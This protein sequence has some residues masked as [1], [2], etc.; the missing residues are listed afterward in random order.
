MENK[1]VKTQLGK[2][3]SGGSRMDYQPPLRSRGQ[4]IFSLLICLGVF[5]AFSTQVSAAPLKVN[6]GDF[7][8]VAAKE[9]SPGQVDLDWV[10]SLSD[11]ASGYSIERSQSPNS[12][13][14]EV[15]RTEGVLCRCSDANL[16]EGQTY[17]YRVRAYQKRWKRVIYSPYSETFSVTTEISSEP[18]PEVSVPG[19]FEFSA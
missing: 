17:F 8:S 14:A 13:F 19:S 5:L 11:S 4:M 16:S 10:F 18:I 9:V 7:I 15:M 2:K 12:G 3:H 1:I 6:S